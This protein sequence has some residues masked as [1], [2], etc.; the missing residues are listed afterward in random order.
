MMMREHFGQQ[1]HNTL[2]SDGVEVNNLW[3]LQAVDNDSKLRHKR[4]EIRE[5]DSL[6]FDQTC[7]RWN[8]SRSIQRLQI[9]QTFRHPCDSRRKDV[10]T[11]H[12]S[13]PVMTQKSKLVTPDVVFNILNA[14]LSSLAASVAT[15]LNTGV[16]LVEGNL[17]V[18]SYKL[19]PVLHVQDSPVSRSVL[20]RKWVQDFIEKVMTVAPVECPAEP[21]M[22]FLVNEVEVSSSI[23]TPPLITRWDKSF[24]TDPLNLHF[25]PIGKTPTRDIILLVPNHHPL[26]TVGGFNLLPGP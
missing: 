10:L 19:S 22:D 18:E 16:A 3:R 6:V 21:W 24:Q 20:V 25:K 26:L 1:L 2:F 9:Y 7:G 17:M 12:K 5:M 11:V 13:Y 14:V 8:S 23:A 15:S 4:N